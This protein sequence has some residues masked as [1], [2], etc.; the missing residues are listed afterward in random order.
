MKFL[1]KYDWSDDPQARGD[2][3]ICFTL[4]PVVLVCIIL[5]LGLAA[6]YYIEDH[7]VRTHQTIENVK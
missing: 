3:I 6:K 5:G 7:Y 4:L 2:Q 1:D